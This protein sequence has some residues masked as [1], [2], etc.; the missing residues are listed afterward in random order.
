MASAVAGADIVINLTGILSERRKGDFYRVHETGAKRI[1][2]AAARSGVRRL[3]HIS[4]IGADSASPSHYARSKALGETAVRAAFPGAIILRP[5]ILFGPEDQFFNRFA[6]MALISP[7]VPIVGANTKFQPVYV[8]D[9][10]DAVLTACSAEAA[11]G[12]L[13]E[14]G[15]PEVKTFR[16]LIEY[17]LKTIERHR[18]ILDLPIGLAK[19]NALFLEHLPGKLLTQ[20]QIKLLQRDNIVAPG[21]LDL[22]SLGIAAAPLD[23]VV[24]GYLSRFCAGGRRALIYRV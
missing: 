9:V 14:L 20:D 10:A 11:A 19:L 15:G 4:A 8:G 7:V 24:P 23:L 2:E 22:A 5:S 1:A 16:Q 13:Y 3:V 6:E 17:M 18:R 12:K 21:A